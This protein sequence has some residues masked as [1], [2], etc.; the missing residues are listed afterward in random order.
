MCYVYVLWSETLRKRYVGSTEDLGKR[1]AQ[2]NAGESVFTKRGMPWRIIHTENYPTRR[3]AE[4]R[5]RELKSGQGRA[6]LDRMYPDANRKSAQ[7]DA[8]KGSGCPSEPV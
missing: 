6:W 1:L 5:E 2:H 3:E 8:K 7:G 4:K